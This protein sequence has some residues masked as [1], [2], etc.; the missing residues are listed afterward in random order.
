MYAYAGPEVARLQK[1][2]QLAEVG[3]E[4][5][6]HKAK[7]SGRLALGSL[8]AFGLTAAISWLDLAAQPYPHTIVS[9]NLAS[10]LTP[11][12]GIAAAFFAGGVVAPIVAVFAGISWAKNSKVAE[13]EEVYISQLSRRIKLAKEGMLK[14]ST[15]V[16]IRSL[17]HH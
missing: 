8:A 4:E 13:E 9:A 11:E 7:K 1:F 12:F 17:E 10:P 15:D 14:E 3:R 6:E 16:N 2:K 5:A